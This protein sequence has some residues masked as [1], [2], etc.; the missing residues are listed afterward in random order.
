M[1]P[2]TTRIEIFAPFSEAFELTKKIL[3][4]PFDPMKW[5]VIGF[6]AWLAT[7]FTGSGSRGYNHDWTTRWKS[8]LT[9]GSFS[10]GQ[11]PAWLIPAVIVGAIFG[12]GLLLLVLWL[13]ARA[14]FIFT[15]C[16]VRNRGAIAEPWREYRQEGNRYFVFQ[17]AISLISIVV[18]GGIGLLW[19]MSTYMGHNILPIVVLFPFGLISLLIMIPVIL[20]IRFAVP[21]MY[22]QRCD[23]LSACKQVWNLIV[24][25][26]GVFIL[27]V[28]FYA[29]LYIA[30]VAIGCLA[31]CITCC[32][33]CIPYIG[34]VLLLPVVMMLYSYP[35]C[36]IRQFGDPYDVWAG[37][38]PTELP[39][40]PPVQE[41]QGTQE[42]PPVVESPPPTS[43]LPPAPPSWEPPSPPPPAPPSST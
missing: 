10:S 32:V 42:P 31:N 37:L 36:F 24:A 15:D 13:N 41:S 33:A 3:F 23:V 25:N 43:P 4:Q 35:L 17:V 29:V 14:R 8:E 19:F 18:F 26:P 2:T 22:R 28:L 30:A 27:F 34:T 39:P 9:E 7:F 11:T 21:V 1:E 40:I 6:A 5:L 16:I 20:V 12:L 38:Q